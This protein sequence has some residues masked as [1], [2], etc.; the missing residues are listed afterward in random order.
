[1]PQLLNLQTRRDSAFST[2]YSHDFKLTCYGGAPSERDLRK[3]R[4]VCYMQGSIDIEHYLESNSNINIYK[5]NPIK[6]ANAEINIVKQSP[7]QIA[8]I[9][10][11]Y[12]YKI[13]CRLSSGTNEQLIVDGDSEIFTFGFDTATTYFLEFNDNSQEKEHGYSYEADNYY[14][15]NNPSFVLE[16]NSTGDETNPD[17]AGWQIVTEYES[18]N[19]IKELTGVYPTTSFTHDEIPLSKTNSSTI[20]VDKNDTNYYDNQSF[21]TLGFVGS[22]SAWPPRQYRLLLKLNLSSYSG[23]SIENAEFAFYI[24]DDYSYS[25]TSGFK[26]HKITRDWNA[27]STTYDTIPTYDPTPLVTIKPKKSGNSNRELHWLPSYSDPYGINT[28]IK[29]LVKEWCNNPESNYGIILIRDGDETDGGMGIQYDKSYLT[30][31]YSGT[32]QETGEYTVKAYENTNNEIDIIAKPNGDTTYTKFK[33]TDNNSIVIEDNITSSPLY[34]T[35][36]INNNDSNQLI[37]WVNITSEDITNSFDNSGELPMSILIDKTVLQQSNLNEIN[38]K[39]GNVFNLSTNLSLG[40]T[41]YLNRWIKKGVTQNTAS[42]FTSDESTAEIIKIN[43]TTYNSDTITNNLVNLVDNI[44]FTDTNA[45]T[46]LYIGNYDNNENNIMIF[47]AGDNNK[48][49]FKIIGLTIE[50]GYDLLKVYTSDTLA[51]L[52]DSE[53]VVAN[54]K[55]SNGI[56]QSNAINETIDTSNQFIGFTFISDSSVTKVGWNIFISATNKETIITDW[57]DI[58]DCFM[59][60]SSKQLDV[61]N[62]LPSDTHIINTSLTN[63]EIANS[64]KEIS[65]H[66]HID[67]INDNNQLQ[68]INSTP[69][70]INNLS[71]KISNVSSEYNYR[72]LNYDLSDNENNS[73]YEISNNFTGSSVVTGT[74]IDISTTELEAPPTLELEAPPTLELEAP[75]T[76]ELEV[77][78]K[79]DDTSYYLQH[80]RN[81]SQLYKKTNLDITNDVL[82]ISYGK[83]Y[84]V[85]NNV[86]GLRVNKIFYDTHID[87]S[88]INITNTYARLYLQFYDDINNNNDTTDICYNITLNDFNVTEHNNI[89]I[90]NNYASIISYSNN[91]NYQQENTSKHISFEDVSDNSKFLWLKATNDSYTISF[92]NPKNIKLTLVNK[93]GPIGN[94]ET[95]KM[96]L[97]FVPLYVSEQIVNLS[98]Q[99]TS[100]TNVEFDLYSNP[101]YSSTRRFK[102][103]SNKFY[104][105]KLNKF[106]YINL[107]NVKSFK[108][109]ILTMNM[110]DIS[111]YD[112][113]YSLIE[114]NRNITIIIDNLTN[115]NIERNDASNNNQETYF[116]TNFNDLNY[117]NKLNIIS[118]SNGSSNNMFIPGD[119]INITSNNVIYT[120][121]FNSISVGQTSTTT[122]NICFR[123]NTLIKT[124]Q[125]DIQIQKLIPQKHTINNKNINKII[126]STT[127][128]DNLVCFTKHSFGF[129]KPSRDLI[130]TCNH[131]ILFNDKLIQ[132]GEFACGNIKI[133]NAYSKR[134]SKGVKFIKYNNEILYNILMD[135]HE[136]IKANNVDCETLNPTNTNSHIE[137][138]VNNYEDKQFLYD[139]INNYKTD[140]HSAIETIK[141]YLV[142]NDEIKTN[143]IINT[144]ILNKK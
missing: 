81:H 96:L 84:F 60:L 124:D 13:Y 85:Y 118:Q 121:Y 14:Y 78:N 111:R 44:I 140:K 62:E 10:K 46:G 122:Q 106:N 5:Q 99:L 127:T 65:K 113:Y 42:N 15:Q 26:I 9:T 51:G 4:V 56:I 39:L 64:T 120:I 38:G 92:N 55:L 98:T 105:S 24:P 22:T 119:E 70:T 101:I 66:Y 1:M 68:F 23:L 53:N 114:D 107:L 88:G 110:T 108:N 28:N 74:Y 100:K 86:T 135:N 115:I 34:L 45:G 63:T 12:T 91:I 16:Y 80:K 18:L 37:Q 136:I 29:I 2:N 142:N 57:N 144:H 126:T 71:K 76:L 73:Y 133:N 33:I 103:R 141:N 17:D 102:I 131:E 89:N 87:N 11:V 35:T 143:N 67:T 125:G 7:V 58:G 94:N 77:I 8:P 129:F 139:L 138:N 36:H 50:V 75:P 116:L 19:Q 30:I 112:A 3:L 40:E 49:S 59:C 134:H 72:V 109:D 32:P 82:D 48:I 27:S 52:I 123:A 69:I 79:K 97:D 54:D 25:T 43:D 128:N 31:A 61:S 117:S 20:S 132:A 90:N 41:Y 95:T 104:D 6:Y 137:L 83:H 21:Q 93:Q 130:V 47:N